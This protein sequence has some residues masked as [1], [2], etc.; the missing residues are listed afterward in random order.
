[1][2]MTSSPGDGGRLLRLGWL[3]AAHRLCHPHAGEPRPLQLRFQAFLHPAGRLRCRRRRLHLR[4]LLIGRAL[5]G[6]YVP[7]T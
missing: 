1:M 2:P 5:Q 6:G 3:G 4:R 7:I